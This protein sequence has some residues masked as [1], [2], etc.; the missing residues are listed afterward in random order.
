MDGANVEMAEEAGEE[1]MFIF[2]MRVEEVEA[3]RKAGYNAQDFVDKS[4]ELAVVMDQ[5]KS[6]FFTPEGHD[7]DEFQDIYNVLMHHDRFFTL[8]DYDAYCKAQ[9]KVNEAYKVTTLFLS[10]TSFTCLSPVRFLPEYKTL[11]QNGYHERCV[12]WQI[13]F[14]SHHHSIR[15]RDL[16]RHAKPGAHAPS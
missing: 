8:A 12:V 4:P 15:D 1:N 14:R 5:L 11:V 3:L 13:L 2:G 9:E 6:G 10:I 7:K 16:G